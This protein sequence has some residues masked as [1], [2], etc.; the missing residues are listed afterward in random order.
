[1]QTSGESPA[2][3]YTTLT[4]EALEAADVW[5]CAGAAWER[6]FLAL[7][8]SRSPF[9]VMTA[10][11][12]LFTASLNLSGDAAGR[13]LQEHGLKAPLLNDA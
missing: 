8:R 9:D 4:V 12:G 7:A 13:L 1:M 3:L 5:K 6:Y 2:N 11:F 10:N